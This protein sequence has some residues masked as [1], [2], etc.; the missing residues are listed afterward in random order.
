MSA[1]IQP[2]VI[3]GEQDTLSL[4]RLQELKRQHKSSRQ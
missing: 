1:E 2:R 4:E 3:T